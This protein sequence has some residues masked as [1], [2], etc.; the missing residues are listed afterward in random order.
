[1]LTAIVANMHPSKME[2]VPQSGKEMLLVTGGDAVLVKK[3]LGQDDV[4]LQLILEW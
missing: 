1:M 3:L 2:R 4:C